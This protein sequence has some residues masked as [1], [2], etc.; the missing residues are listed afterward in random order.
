MATADLGKVIRGMT[1][2]LC[3]GPT[4]LT[5]PFPHGGTALGEVRDMEFRWGIR[6]RFVTAEEYGGQ[7]VA[8]IPYVGQ[9]DVLACVLRTW[10]DDALAAVFPYT[11]VGVTGHRAI[12][13]DV[14]TDVV[15][16][17]GLDTARVAKI[18][19]SPS[20][21]DQHR[22]IVLH[23]A[24]PLVDESARLQLRLDEEIGIAVVFRGL[25]DANGLVSSVALR[26]D[27]TL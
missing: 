24:M 9:S 18:C 13:V 3:S 20:S 26:K 6:T 11:A 22:F 16:A 10:D 12:K 14:K 19:F 25:P 7:I 17:G 23:R 15:R 5:L 2:Y 4:D 21:P 8:G 27:V 1:G